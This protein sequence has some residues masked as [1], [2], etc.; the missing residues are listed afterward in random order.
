MPKFQDFAAWQ[1]AEALMQPAFIRLIDNIRKQLEDSSWKG[2]YIDTSTWSPDVTE[3]VK[4]QVKQLQ[5]ELEKAAPNEVDAI[6]EALA[7]LPAPVTSYQLCL[8][9]NGQQVPIDLWNLCYQI[10]LQ[11]Y[12]TASDRSST[13]TDVAQDEV[14]VDTSLFDENGEVDWNRLDEKTRQ[15]VEA[16]FAGLPSQAGNG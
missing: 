1:Q 3:E 2:S 5:A 14:A 7:A 13:A 16:I 11:D 6:E 10:C 4:F 15:V 12:D 9:Q 8:E